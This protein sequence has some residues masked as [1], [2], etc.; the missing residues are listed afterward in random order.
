VNLYQKRLTEREKELE[1]AREACKL[2]EARF[3]T[4]QE[5]LRKAIND[6]HDSDIPVPDRG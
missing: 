5:E 4:A 2:A 3:E 6:E 1:E